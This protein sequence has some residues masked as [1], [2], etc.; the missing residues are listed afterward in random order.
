MELN[1]PPFS[2]VCKKLKESEV[3]EKLDYTTPND[4][5]SQFITEN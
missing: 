4:N 2:G 5:E 1:P 3:I